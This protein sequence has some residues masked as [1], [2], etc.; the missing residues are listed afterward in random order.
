MARGP[1]YI[2]FSFQINSLILAKKLVY[3]LVRDVVQPSYLLNMALPSSTLSS[4]FTTVVKQ[5]QVD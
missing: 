2:N 3:L 5:L 1:M 4:N